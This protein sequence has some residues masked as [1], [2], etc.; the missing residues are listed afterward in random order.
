MLFK[1]EN[2][3]SC[4]RINYI[5]HLFNDAFKCLAA[6][7]RIKYST[8]EAFAQK[9]DAHRGFTVSDVHKQIHKAHTLDFEE[10]FIWNLRAQKISK[11]SGQK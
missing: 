10:E 8:S 5:V 9:N 2:S 1:A 7:F 6:L 4:G 3:F 11:Q